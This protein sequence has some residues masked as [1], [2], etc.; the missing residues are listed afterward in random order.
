MA[1]LIAG[2]YKAQS[3]IRRDAPPKFLNFNFFLQKNPVII[4]SQFILMFMNNIYMQVLNGFLNFQ[5]NIFGRRFEAHIRLAIETNIL[6]RVAA[7][8]N[9]AM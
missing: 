3:P 9:K 1:L 4:L 2:R 6:S 5:E 8:H 7:L